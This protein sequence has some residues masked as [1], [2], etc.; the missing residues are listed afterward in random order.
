[1]RRFP[2]CMLQTVC[3]WGRS[4]SVHHSIRESATIPTPVSPSF[5][6][7][8]TGTCGRL[9]RS[10]QQFL[11]HLTRQQLTERS[12]T[13]LVH[14]VG[15]PHVVLRSPEAELLGPTHVLEPASA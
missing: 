9:N 6:D 14:H 7:I 13:D 2:V 12:R 4:G 3:G 8:S 1:M 5:R 15:H 10:G 11:L